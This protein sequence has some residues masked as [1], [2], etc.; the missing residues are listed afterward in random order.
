MTDRR[1][2]A[3]PLDLLEVMDELAE[4]SRML[5][6][7][8]VDMVT[9]D[10][11]A[12]RARC[13][14][15]VAFAAAFLRAEGAMDIRK[16]AAVLLVQVQRLEAELADARLRACRERIRT[17]RDQI[18]VRRSLASALKAQWAAEPAGQW[19]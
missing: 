11:A 16:S 6:R 13:A 4:T 8:T 9:L 18:E 19:T 1:R 12:V 2:W 14:Y 10:E 7:A 3:K 5:D 17:L 15:E